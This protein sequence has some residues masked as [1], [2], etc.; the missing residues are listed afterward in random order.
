MTPELDGMVEPE[1]IINGTKLNF[2]QA[3][4]VRVAIE[5]FALYIFGLPAKERSGVFDNY[6]ACISGLRRFIYANQ[7]GSSPGA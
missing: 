2:G 5:Q 3:M 4:T 6:M 7:P 1:I